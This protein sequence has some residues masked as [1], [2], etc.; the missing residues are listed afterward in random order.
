MWLPAADGRRSARAVIIPFL[1]A[2]GHRVG[3]K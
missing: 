3:G 1:P 2:A